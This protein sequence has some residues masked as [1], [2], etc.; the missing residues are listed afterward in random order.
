MEDFGLLLRL[1]LEFSE[2][3]KIVYWP[4]PICQL[5]RLHRQREL[6]QLSEFIMEELLWSI[7]GK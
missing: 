3:D 2:N 7:D 6:L 5:P 4:L 1:I